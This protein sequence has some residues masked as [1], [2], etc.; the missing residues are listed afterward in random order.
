MTIARFLDV[1]THRVDLHYVG[2][3]HLSWARVF[4][5]GKDRTREVLE[6]HWGTSG[7]DVDEGYLKAIGLIPNYYLR[8][9]VHPDRVV[10]EE[11]A[12]T[13]TRGEYL[14]QVEADTLKLYEDPELRIKPPQLQQRGGAF[15]STAAVELIRSIAQDKRDVQILN[16][17]NGLCLPDLPQDSAVEVPAVVGA[18]GITPLTMG[19]MPA[20]IR[21]LVASV[22]AYE[23]L[24]IEAAITGDEDKAKL[25]LLNH[26][27][28]PS[29]DVAL[30]I[31]DDLKAAHKAYLPQF[32]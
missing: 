2:L 12:A 14:Q 1:E 27:L 4:V 16:V 10:A 31:W 20:S 25:A 7:G 3:N 24:T 11:Q 6:V 9:F 21:G 23:E 17:R 5:D 13:Q 18:R 29:W 22:K 32:A 15:Y 8:Y 28:V 26:P 30:A 19:P